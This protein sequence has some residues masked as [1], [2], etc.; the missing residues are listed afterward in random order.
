MTLACPLISNTSITFKRVSLT[1][2]RSTC[3]NLKAFAFCIEFRLRLKM[4]HREI[5]TY[6]KTAN[7]LLRA[8]N[9]HPGGEILCRPQSLRHFDSLCRRDQSSAFHGE[10]QP[11]QWNPVA[12][13]F[14]QTSKPFSGGHRETTS[15]SWEHTVSGHSL[16]DT[17]CR[18]HSS[19]SLLGIEGQYGSC[20]YYDWRMS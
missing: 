5:L 17:N 19:R 18:Y 9:H 14:S 15:D 2:K 12:Q 16:L 4:P 6:F 8:K 3:D 7:K 20:E 1:W 13:Q 10:N 11:D